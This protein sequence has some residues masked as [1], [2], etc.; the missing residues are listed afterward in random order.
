[1]LLGLATIW[2]SSFLL[3]KVAVRDLAPTSVIAGRIGLG[4]LT[5]AAV[6]PFLAGN[7][8]ALAELR[9]RWRM[10]AVVGAVNTALPFLLITWGQQYIDT[11]V[12]AVFNASAPIWA[13]LLAFAFVRSER[14]VGL[15]LAGVLVGF[16]GIVL[17]IG[18]E[19]TG[20]DNV[21][22]GSLAVVAAA[23]MYALGALITG[24]RLTDV[25]PLGIALGV[26]LWGSVLTVPIGLAQLPGNDVTWEAGAAVVGLGV[27]A[28]GV[29]Y[30]L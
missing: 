18:F 17:L 14:V 10:L 1:M 8:D 29:A 21:V 30:L 19:P 26:L 6:L 23:A 3:I 25:S 2:G 12:A 15:R 9:T 7:R 24:R 28:T 11:G 16:V 20:G 4:F 27:A 22:L 5:L 13:A